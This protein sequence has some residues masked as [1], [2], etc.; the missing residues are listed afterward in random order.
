[1]LLSSASPTVDEF[2]QATGWEL[3][4]QGACR[5]DVCIPLAADSVVDGTVDLATVTERL[6]MGLVSDEESGLL[7]VGPASPGGRVLVTTE[8][9]DLELPDFDGHPF[10]LG[11]L[12]GTKVVLVAWAP[13]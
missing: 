12:R 13:Y 10:R 7:A 3:E 8:A 4:P 1:M 6:G 9:P 11:S 2:A 5:G